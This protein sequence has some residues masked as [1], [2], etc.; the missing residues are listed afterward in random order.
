[1][2]VTTEDTIVV[3]GGQSKAWTKAGRNGW[4]GDRDRGRKSRRGRRRQSRKKERRKDRKQEREKYERQYRIEVEEGRGGRGQ[5]M[6]RDAQPG[7]KEVG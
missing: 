2:P 7:K 6:K 3:G 1:M 4:E 5:M